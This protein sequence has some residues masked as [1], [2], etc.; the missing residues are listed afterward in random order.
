VY[1]FVVAVYRITEIVSTEM[2]IAFV[3]KLVNVCTQFV[4][5]ILF[6][7][8]VDP[9]K[10]FSYKSDPYYINSPF[11]TPC[12]GGLEYLHRSPCESKE[13]TEREHSL[14]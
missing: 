12:G 1:H 4:S 10:K 11:C 5:H 2:L 7:V 8:I 13:A 6:N 3:Q 14:R 9:N